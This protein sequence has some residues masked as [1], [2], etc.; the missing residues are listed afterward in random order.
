MKINVI[1]SLQNVIFI[2]PYSC[3]LQY[4]V[5]LFTSFVHFPTAQ[6]FRRGNTVLHST[7]CSERPEFAFAMDL[8]TLPTRKPLLLLMIKMAGATVFQY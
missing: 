4:H 3:I 5:Q 6:P 8:L 1:V 2:S 7:L